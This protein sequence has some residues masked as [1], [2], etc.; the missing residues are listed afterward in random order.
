LS[1]LKL[2]IIPT[3]VKAVERLK[4]HIEIGKRVD[5]RLDSAEG[6]VETR[7]P[8]DG[9]HHFPRQTMQKAQET[10][11]TEALC[12][13]L[14][15]SQYERTS[16]KQRDYPVPSHIKLP[17]H[18]PCENL[19]HHIASGD[20]AVLTVTYH[21]D[22]P[23]ERPIFVNATLVDDAQIRDWEDIPDSFLESLRLRLNV[24]GD[25][26][27]LSQQDQ[28]TIA[29]EVEEHLQQ[30]QK[31]YKAWRD[32]VETLEAG[33]NLPSV[34]VKAVHDLGVPVNESITQDLAHRS[35]TE[36]NDLLDRLGEIDQAMKTLKEQ[37]VKKFS[38]EAV[39]NVIERAMERNKEQLTEKTQKT[40]QRLEQSVLART[41]GVQ[42]NYMGIQWPYTEPAPGWPYRDRP[43]TQLNREGWSYNPALHRMEQH[44]I[45]MAWDPN[46]GSF[47]ANVDLPLQQPAESV[48]QVQGRLTVAT[49]KLISGA[50][51]T[52][53]NVN[54]KVIT[55]IPIT[56]RT[57]V[58][59][60][61][62]VNLEEA[63]RR[64]IFLPHRSLFFSDV[65]P[66]PER[67]R[68]VEGVLTDAGLTILQRSYSRQESAVWEKPLV[69]Q[70]TRRSL[71][72]PT[73]I[74]VVLRGEQTTGQHT[75]FFD[76]GRQQVE[77][78]ISLGNL[79]LDILGQ[80]IGDPAPI[81]DILDDIQ[82]RLQRRMGEV[83]ATLG[84][85]G[86]VSGT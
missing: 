79:R 69:I 45:K 83:S 67:L 76:Q 55:S 31:T 72:L 11:T 17:L 59:V 49:D 63:F 64:R 61:L 60:N 25:L 7:V 77:R 54:E 15:F 52:W 47:E 71:G 48:P 32:I 21:L 82:I 62:T 3:S 34:Q 50:Q 53:L 19:E 36:A 74:W 14:G 26:S 65:R 16:L 38:A 37:Q 20:D 58:E 44:D 39:C 46:L 4:Y 66:S 22:E 85:C 8:Y 30:A 23:A 43:A 51:I 84:Q 13:Y 2:D 24:R 10:H 81:S 1:D 56:F 12:G 33:K 57:V 6:K 68:E 9:T 73:Q 18:I 75:A 86:P 29:Q 80:T 70:A 78:E 40:L 42:I 5:V 28:N 35:M 27:N 41:E